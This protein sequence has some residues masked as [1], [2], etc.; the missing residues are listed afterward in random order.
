MI[1]V[2]ILTK[3]SQ[4]TI[5]AALESAILFSETI[6]LDSGSTDATLSI[7][8]EYS[9]VRIF[10]TEF[11]GFGPLRNEAAGLAQNDW[12]LAL[13]SD[14]VLSSSLSGE[15]GTLALDP[16]AAYSIPRHNF[17]NGKRICGCGWNPERVARLYHRRYA[18]YSDAQV[19]ESLQAKREIPLS[20]P[21]LHTPY[22]S[23]ADFL[24][25]MQHY[26]TLFAEQYC[27]KRK[28]SFGKALAHGAFAFFKSYLLKRGL[29]DGAEGF[30]IS[31]Y[32]ANTAF[33]KYLKLAEANRKKT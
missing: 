2:C 26:S 6:L 25:K 16:N 7:A 10:K 12:I 20:S 8:S 24:A 17:Y 32:N 13:D 31:L 14:E 21:L 30:S 23:T 22:R 18:R 27:G 19:H 33:Y 1:S 3:N 15:I 9:N 29:F 4:E 28:S 5:R 11:K